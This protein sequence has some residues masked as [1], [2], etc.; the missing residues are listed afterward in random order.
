MVGENGKQ[1]ISQ[2]DVDHHA[3]V[4]T[5]NKKKQQQK[6]FRF[7]ER[8]FLFILSAAITETQLCHATAK[9]PFYSCDCVLGFYGPNCTSGERVA[10]NVVILWRCWRVNDEQQHDV[11]FYNH[12]TE[13]MVTSLFSSP[14]KGLLPHFLFHFL[15]GVSIGINMATAPTTFPTTTRARGKEQRLS[16]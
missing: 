13:A 3:F 11:P 1:I 12:D 14:F 2:F 6:E 5:N 8:C 4:K 9:T 10:V 16:A 7:F 15:Q